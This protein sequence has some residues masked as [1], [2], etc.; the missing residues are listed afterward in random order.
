MLRPAPGGLTEFHGW[1]E[2]RVKAGFAKSFCVAAVF[3]RWFVERDGPGRL[4]EITPGERFSCFS[5]WHLHKAV[6]SSS[7]SPG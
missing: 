4:R 7:A 2:R 1:L 6:G 5:K 3:L